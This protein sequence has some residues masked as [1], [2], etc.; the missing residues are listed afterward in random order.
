MAT[1]S[2]TGNERAA[3]RRHLLK[4]IRRYR[5]VYLLFLP[6]LAFI[7]VFRYVP[8]VSQ[9][10]LA[11]KNYQ[12]SKGVFASPWAGFAW[13]AK[14][15]SS[16]DFPIIVRNTVAIAL[17]RLLWGFWPPILIAILLD[18]LWSRRF[19]QFT[20]S[21]LYLPHFFSWI[22]IYGIAWTFLSLDG[23]INTWV[24]ALGGK[25]ANFL[26]LTPWFRP[27]IIALG[28]WK[29][30][31][32]GTIIYLAGLS[33]IDPQLYEAGRMDGIG[34]F[35]RIWFITLPQL[36]PVI[37]FVLTLSLGGLLS[38]GFEQVFLFQSPATYE[39]SDVIETWVYRRGLLGMEVSF[40]TA[41]GLFQS[42]IGLALILT[43]N[44]LA[45]KFADTGIW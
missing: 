13:F 21:I 8:I 26:V 17:L 23:V 12:F 38:A 44:W 29:E 25:K 14:A 37:V 43:G 10:M 36:R 39:V 20:Q 28:I 41:V 33:G 45:R 7:V 2:I 5:S 11:F 19:R 6:I 42:A 3:R 15:F 1:H 27:V 9:V 24:V 16:I 32:W 40:G 30:L 34:V 18:D 31:G 35:Q 22:I 4:E